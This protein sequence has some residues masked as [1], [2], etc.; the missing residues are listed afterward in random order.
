MVG[1]CIGQGC[2]TQKMK[3]TQDSGV[4]NVIVPANNLRITNV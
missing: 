4:R 2:V 3:T 1:F